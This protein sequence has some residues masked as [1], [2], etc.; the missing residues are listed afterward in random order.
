DVGNAGGSFLTN[1]ALHL[2][3]ADWTNSSLLQAQKLTLDI[4]TFTQSASGKLIS[5]ES[6]VANGGTWHNDGSIETDGEL[7]LNLTGAYSGAGKLL[8]Q[9]GMSLTADSLR[10]D[11]GAEVR[12]GGD[13]QIEVAGALSN[14]GTLTAAGDMK[15]KAAALTNRD[16]LGATGSLQLETSTLR[17]EGGLI[18]SGGDMQLLG[19][20]HTNFK[21]DIYSLGDLTIARNSAA[22]RAALL[23]N[24][25]GTIESAGDMR[26]F[27]GTIVNR[28]DTFDVAER[29]VSGEIRYSCSNCEGSNY[30]LWYYI[31]EIYERYIVS[32]SAAAAL[33]SGGILD[34]GGS[35]FVNSN[36]SVSAVDDISI[37]VDKFT[38]EGTDLEIITHFMRYKN[39]ADSESGSVFRGLISPGGGI[40]E[41][42]KYNSIYIP[43]YTD[44]NGDYYYKRINEVTSELNPYFDISKGV[45]IPAKILSYGAWLSTQTATSSGNASP[46]II[47]SGKNVSITATTALDN[48]VRKIN[49]PIDQGYS[50]AQTVEAPSSGLIYLVNLNGQ[51]PADLSQQSVNPLTLPSI[52]LPQGQTGLFHYNSDPK[53]PYLIETNPTF[54]SLKAFLSSDYMLERLGYSTDEAQ[55]R[56]GDG[57]Y[58]QRLIRE[59]IV[60]RTGKRFLDGLTSDEAM[61]RYLMDN[62]IASKEALNLS[63]GVALTAEQVAALTHDIVWLQEQEIDGQK[64]LVPVLYL[65]QAKDRLGPNGALIQGRDLTLIS[66]GELKN[67]GTLRASNDLSATAA[68]IANSGLMQANE[69]LSLLASDSILNAQGGIIAGKDVSAMALLGDVTNERT[70]SR[71]QDSKGR[72]HW[73]QDFVDSAARIEADDSLAISAG[74]DI[75]NIGSVLD[76]GGDIDLDAGQDVLIAAAQQEGG[77]TGG[78]RYTNSRI[79]QYE[80]QVKAGGDLNVAAERD[81]VVVGSQLAADRD[82]AIGAG[83]DVVLTSAANEQHHYSKSDDTTRQE[84]HVHQQETSLQ[85]GNDLYID[86]GGDLTLSASKAVAA[87]EAYLV[88]GGRLSLLS[89]QN[90]DYSLYDMKKKGSWGSKETQRDEVTDIRNIGSS[91]ITGGDLTL[92]SGGDQLYQKA[93]LESGADLTLDSGGSITFEAVKDLK[94]ESHEKSKSDWSWNSAKGKGKT[95]ETL[96]QS[97]LIAQ[98]DIVIQAVDGLKI[99]IK[100]VNKQTVSQTID[101]MVQADPQLAW[102]KQAEARG[103]VDW[104]RVKEIHESFKYSN[105]GLGAGAQLI[106]A[107]AMAAIIGPMAAGLGAVGQAVTVSVATQATVSTINN[108]GNLGAVAKDVTSSNAMKGYVVSAATAGLVQY[109]PAELGM[110]WSSV[111][112]V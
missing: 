52:S 27:A 7:S 28:K 94:Q 87:G 79:T 15:L 66:G 43:R 67:Q 4:G 97:E 107:I 99:D 72:W 62:A 74:R 110:N 42:N 105:S 38:N 70:V 112:Q 91:I 100:H 85:A 46:A 44:S 92:I 81:V 96:R 106:I 36:S 80:A 103:D 47:Q 13:G 51:L 6:I 50:R 61:F 71:Y 101:A 48:G 19:D 57:L 39:P 18:F 45:P 40:Y 89:A 64:V 1:G 78:K 54:A 41:Y 83:G 65:A 53:H 26:I 55:R 76:S 22:D 8:S 75:G 108:R 95:D 109:N 31:T 93:H 59:A 20:S 5:A 84:D 2:N 77:I 102:L 10:L 98:G 49:T 73:A 24:I 69:R 37:A 29:K 16:T 23:E 30:D 12:S 56:L 33:V 63:V 21:G 32:D 11:T 58:E 9:T 68:T 90:Q 34:I 111:G 25:S 3:V 14:A 60:A 35:T 82:I 17:N 104:R 88:A 86:A